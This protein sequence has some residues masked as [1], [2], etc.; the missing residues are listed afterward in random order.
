[1]ISRLAAK[2]TCLP[3]ALLF[4]IGCLSAALNRFIKAGQYWTDVA[5]RMP[6]LCLYLVGCVLW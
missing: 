4:L 6:F 2:K 5:M 3:S 1:M